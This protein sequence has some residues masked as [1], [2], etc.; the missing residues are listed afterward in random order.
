MI[1]AIFF[2]PLADRMGR[3]KVIMACFIIF[4]AFTGLCGVADSPTSFSIYRF[5]GGLGLGGIMPNVIA[6]MTDY[7]PRKDEKLNR[8]PC[9]LRIFNWWYVSTDIIHLFSS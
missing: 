4:S 1:G 2:G 6:L 5:I 8:F 3:K 9:T 7:S